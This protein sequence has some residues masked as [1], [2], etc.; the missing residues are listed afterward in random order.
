MSTIR[1][2]CTALNVTALGLWLGCVV[3]TGAAAAVIFP[4]IKA[5]APTAPAYAQYTGEQWLIVAGHAAARV[6]YISDIIQ[7]A[8]AAIVLATTVALAMS[9]RGSLRGRASMFRHTMI[10]GAFA[11]FCYYF[12]ILAPQMSF[13]LHEHWQAAAA[14]DNERAARFKA[15]FDAD[16]PSSS[17]TLGAIA[18]TLLAALLAT[19]WPRSGAPGAAP[20]SAPPAPRSGGKPRLEEPAL[21]RPKP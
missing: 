17:N 11:F 19:A 9:D 7:F 8:C 3:M 10:A 4:S 2:I 14:G 12:F 21:L 13:A 5:L 20:S 6:F 1:S 16:H 15:A 18:V